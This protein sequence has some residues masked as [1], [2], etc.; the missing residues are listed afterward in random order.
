MW[1]TLYEF[2]L[3]IVSLAGTFILIIVVFSWMI[4]AIVPIV[5]L[6]YGLS[7]YY[8]ATFREVK[9]LDANMRSYLY[10]YFSE[11]LTGLRILKAYNVVHKAILK[12]E[13]RIDL[14]NRPYYM[15]Q[16]GARW[17][18]LGVNVLGALPTFMV[19]ILI[20]ATRFSVNPASA[21]L[22]LSYLS[23]I[24][25]DLNWGVQRL[26]TLENNMN[27]AERLVYYVNNV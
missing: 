13:Y 12:N 8:R 24:S 2:T 22:T 14:N 17:L 5:I 1:S 3:T 23:R 6:Y 10:A 19:V 16:L 7:I 20:T 11:S 9:R 26:L 21:G 25:G 27:P 18:S 4:L 15:Y